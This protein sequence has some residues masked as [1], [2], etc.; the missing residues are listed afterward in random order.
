[1]W[2][3]TK[4]GEWVVYARATALHAGTSLYVTAKSGDTKSVRIASVGRPFSVGG[5]DMAYGYVSD[6]KPRPAS[7]SRRSSTGR[8]C[9]TCGGPYSDCIGSCQ[10]GEDF[11]HYGH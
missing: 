11:G 5:V 1:M 9:Y 4:S 6:T 3:K 8:R 2:R 7:S 10:L